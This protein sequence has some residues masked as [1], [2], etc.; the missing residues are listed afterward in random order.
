MADADCTRAC[1]HCGEAITPKINKATDLPS[2]AVR[3]YCSMRCCWAFHDAKRGHRPRAGERI[4]RPAECAVCGKGFESYAS[5][6]AP[7][8]WT[9]CCSVACGRRSRDIRNGALIRMAI[10]QSVVK[11]VTHRGSCEGCGTR[12]TRAI[13]GARYCSD[14][15][16]P[17]AYAWVPEHRQ[18][19]EC[20]TGFMQTIKWQRLCS[21]ECAGAQKTRHNRIGKLTRKARVKGRDAESIDPMAVF[22]RDGWRCH[23]CGCKTLERLRGSHNPRAPELEHIVSLADGGSHTWGNVACS[24][25]ACNQAKGARSMGQLGMPFA[26]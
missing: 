21:D 6:G 8:G 19:S 3:R 20:G 10:R 2:K 18:C 12:F 11:V 4:K 13:M 7:G 23:L 16:W 17:S 22:R 1:A 24:C 15:C 26:A 14:A 9:Q 25:R 5:T